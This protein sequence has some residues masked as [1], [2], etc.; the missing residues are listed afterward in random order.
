M[1]LARTDVIRPLAAG[2]SPRLD[3][4]GPR[5]AAPNDRTLVQAAAHIRRCTFRRVTARP[6]GRRELPMYDVDCL[7]PSYDAAVSLGDLGAAHDAC[8]ACALPGIFR[9]DE[10]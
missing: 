5:V 10:D 6:H 9:P 4:H 3:E 8:A 1:A 7:H 2:T